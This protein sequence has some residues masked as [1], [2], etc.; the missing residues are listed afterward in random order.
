MNPDGI[1]GRALWLNAGKPYTVPLS[2]DSQARL[3]ARV[4]LLSH[5]WRDGRT[6]LRAA[7]SATDATGRTTRLWSR[8]VRPSD[9]GPGP[10]PSR[11]EVELPVGTVALH[12]ELTA[13]G[14]LRPGSVTRAVWLEPMLIDPLAAALPAPAPVPPDRVALLLGAP[15][16][17]SPDSGA[18]PAAVHARGGDRVGSGPDVHQ[19]G[20]LP[21]R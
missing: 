16:R 9:R 21:C 5:D 20:A 4:M 19:L 1:L 10:R 6:P 11:L 15:A 18:Q 7:V 12:L 17:L 2:L 8:K 13:V 14:R 3:Q